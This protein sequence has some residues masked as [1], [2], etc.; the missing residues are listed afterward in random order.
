MIDNYGKLQFCDENNVGNCTTQIQMIIVPIAWN[1][2][3]TTQI[4]FEGDEYPVCF[5]VVLGVSG[6]TISR[7]RRW[8]DHLILQGKSSHDRIGKYNHT[9]VDNAA[10]ALF[11]KNKESG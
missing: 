4:R 10:V 3:E 2:L 7:I 11:L 5:K 6:V 1:R 8:Q 9:T